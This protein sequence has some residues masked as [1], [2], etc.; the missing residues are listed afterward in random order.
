MF[1]LQGLKDPNEFC[2]GLALL[3]GTVQQALHEVAGGAGFDAAIKK[4]HDVFD[5]L[6]AP[7]ITYCVTTALIREQIS[8]AREDKRT[9]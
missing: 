8:C 1:D 3:D 2:K 4:A 6:P 5:E 7:F 9:G